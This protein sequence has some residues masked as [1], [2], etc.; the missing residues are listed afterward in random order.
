ML[1]SSERYVLGYVGRSEPCPIFLGY[2]HSTFV[3]NTKM[4]IPEILMHPLFIA[5]VFLRLNQRAPFFSQGIERS[6]LRS[7][8][9]FNEARSLCIGPCASL[10]TIQGASSEFYRVVPLEPAD[11][12]CLRAERPALIAQVADQFVDRFRE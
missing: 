7:P 12:A 1:C 5:A 6:F 4:V 3:A 9:G 10:V 8:C 2:V 11:P